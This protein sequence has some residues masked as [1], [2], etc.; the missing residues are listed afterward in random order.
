ML[1][2]EKGKQMTA[3]FVLVG[4]AVLIL[5]TALMFKRRGGNAPPDEAWPVYAKKLLSPVEQILY[6][7]LVKALPEDLVLA[8]VQLSR[9]IGIKKGH[10]FHTWNNRINR[11][12]VDFVVCTKN[13]SVIAAIELDDATHANV[14]RAAADTKK[15]RVLAAAGIRVIRWRAN[16]LPDDVSIQSAIRP[17]TVASASI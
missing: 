14:D 6:F 7:R 17:L 12:S 5:V 3:L 10:N 1:R 4:V 9:L 13:A 11:M 15:D 2:P 16:A 8:Q